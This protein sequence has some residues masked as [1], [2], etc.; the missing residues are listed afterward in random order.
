LRAGLEADDKATGAFIELLHWLRDVLLQDSVFLMAKYP[1]HPVFQ[2]PVFWSPQF[3]A[4]AA[5]VKEAAQESFEDDRGTAIEKAIPEVSEKLRNLAAYQLTVEKAVE[6]RHFELVQEVKQLKAQVADMCRMEY[7]V[8][9]T[10]TPGRGYTV[11]SSLHTSKATSP[12]YHH[13]RSHYAEHQQRC[14]P[15]PRLQRSP[16]QT[17]AI[18]QLQ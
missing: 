2:D 7:Q 13:R 1:G 16:G 18:L 17:M 6:R 12:P 9:T 15:D 5:K 3:N 14:W 4:F 8:V 11:P 10:F